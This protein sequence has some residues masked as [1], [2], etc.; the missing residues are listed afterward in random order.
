MKLF[1]R[2]LLPFL[3]CVYIATESYLKLNNISLCEASGCKIAGELLKFE[4]IYLNYV[5]VVGVF[6]LMI[7]GYRSI[8]S[9]FFEV[10]FFVGLYSAIAFEATILS[11]QWIVNPELCL[12]CLGIFGSL[13]VIAFFASMRHFIVVLASVVSITGALYAL[14]IVTNQAYLTKS[15]YYLVQSNSCS[16]CKKVKAY[17]KEHQIDYAPIAISEVNARA[18]LK[19]LDMGTIPVLIE[20]SDRG[21]E[22]IKGDQAIIAHFEAQKAPST[23]PQESSTAPQSSLTGTSSALPSFLM[24]P[25]NGGCEITV[26]QEPTCDEEITQP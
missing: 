26:T 3:L 12:F 17:L 22:I 16:H 13:L 2:V 5:G 14:N 6:A 10:L 11:Y 19:F 15:G 9:R 21:V 18:F 8:K 25:D 7:F 24:Q 23:P 4:A 20:K 1:A